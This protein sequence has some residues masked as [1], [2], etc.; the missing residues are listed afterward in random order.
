MKSVSPMEE[1]VHL[2][3]FPSTQ[4]SPPLEFTEVM[5]GSDNTEDLPILYVSGSLLCISFYL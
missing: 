5:L 1:S 4:N 3:S 2:S